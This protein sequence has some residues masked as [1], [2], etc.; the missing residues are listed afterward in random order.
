MLRTE[1]AAI[2]QIVPLQI[3]VST[4]KDSSPINNVEIK[5][6][7]ANGIEMI[8]SGDNNPLRRS[9]E[10]GEK[11]I[12]KPIVKVSPLIMEQGAASIDII[13]E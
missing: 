2:D 8:S 5:I 11:Y 4:D 1:S 12:F 7:S 9:I 13:C 3:E 10:G 6:L